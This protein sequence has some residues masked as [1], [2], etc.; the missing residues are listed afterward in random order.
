MPDQ[1]HLLRDVQPT[2][3]T[4]CKQGANRQRIFLK[5]E[6]KDEGL[7][8]LPGSHAV[9]RKA[10]GED[11]SYFYC[12]VAEPGAR[13]DPGMGD[14]AGSSIEDMWASEDE[15]R[16]AAHYF[17]KSQMLVTGLHDTIEPF[18]AVVENALAPA[19]FEVE[20]PDGTQTIR[21]GSW[22]VG[23]QP[24]DEGKAK[25]DA[26]E[27]TGL[28]LEGTG[29]RELAELQKAQSDE[30][31]KRG[32]LKKMADYFGVDVPVE[33]EKEKAPTFN[34]IIT[35]REVER[36]LDDS[37]SVLREVIWSATSPSYEGDSGKTIKA[38]AQQFAD[39]IGRIVDGSDK[40]TPQALAKE[41]GTVGKT[42]EEDDLDAA[43]TEKISKIDGLESGVAD[44]KKEASATSQAITQLTG[45]VET[46]ANKLSPSKD[47][48]DA[49]PTASD[50]KKSIDELTD[51]VNGKLDE[52]ESGV[53][54]LADSGSSQD[55]DDEAEARLRKA[56]EQDPL[57]GILS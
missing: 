49:A 12:V 34:D 7:I 47:G 31:E 14:G 4:L 52:L 36:A 17:A 26:G 2:V 54:A 56:R 55:N 19:D 53:S 1:V 41:L 6:Q 40:K 44:L 29:Y 23:I 3:L 37:F 16:K 5:K 33:L 32:L 48:D 42:N 10:E 8:E 45:L 35:E 57:A 27:F 21:K 28:S 24:S 22:Y 25:I 50:L 15:I 46:L 11:W 9:I 20:G 39:Y 51:T 38:S 13:E 43:T 30:D 18:G